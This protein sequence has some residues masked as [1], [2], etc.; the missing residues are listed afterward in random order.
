[1]AQYA[2]MQKGPA[3]MNVPPDKIPT[4]EADGWVVIQ[5]PTGP[6]ASSVPPAEG[7]SVEKTIETVVKR[8]K[9]N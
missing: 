4:Y 7:P 9:K 3:T 1:M 8:T 5:A 2:L 6:E